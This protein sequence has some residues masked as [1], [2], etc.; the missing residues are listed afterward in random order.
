MHG[1]LPR[2]R[3]HS[4]VLTSQLDP[5]VGILWDWQTDA[6]IL[7]PNLPWSYH[8]PPGAHC[9]DKLIEATSE[10]LDIRVRQQQYPS[11]GGLDPDIEAGC[12]A[13]IGAG[14]QTIRRSLAKRGLLSLVLAVVD[15]DNLVRKA[16]RLRLGTK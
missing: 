10:Q 11:G 1:S 13:P 8:G 16:E 2:P 15:H 9:T 6:S 12:I 4:A 7:V 3:H 5:G 14:D